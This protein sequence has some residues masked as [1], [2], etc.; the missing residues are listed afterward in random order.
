MECTFGIMKGRWRILKYGIRLHGIDKCD[1]IWMTCCALHNMLLEV[2]GYDKYWVEES[3]SG[4]HFAVSR[5]INPT[6]FRDLSGGGV[7]NDCE[8]MPNNVDTS[9]G[10]LP[11]GDDG[12]ESRPSHNFDGSININDLSLNQFRSCLIRHFNIAFQKQEVSWPIAS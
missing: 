4:N 5:L 2:D 12:D 10:F 1:Q 7:G 9:D 8:R 6:S 3:G 11:A